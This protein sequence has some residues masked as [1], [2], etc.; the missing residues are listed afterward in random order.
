MSTYYLQAFVTGSS[1]L[2]DVKGREQERQCY[3]LY[4]GLRHIAKTSYL[5][6]L[7][8][9]SLHTDKQLLSLW[10]ETYDQVCDQCVRCNGPQAEQLYF[11]E[12]FITFIKSMHD[13]SV[14][15]YDSRRIKYLT[16]VAYD[17]ENIIRRWTVHCRESPSTE[18]V[19]LNNHRY[20]HDLQ[21]LFQSLLSCCFAVLLSNRDDSMYLTCVFLLHLIF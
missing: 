1:L 11:L 6:F 19:R 7:Q 18:E 2:S 17:S 14:P 10:K 12:N 16:K 20:S 8:I 3:S 4:M 9:T 13:I 5:C 15:G 21:C